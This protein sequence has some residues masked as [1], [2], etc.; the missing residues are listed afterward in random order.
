[1]H[2]TLGTQTIV[3]L[4]LFWIELRNRKIISVSKFDTHNMSRTYNLKVKFSLMKRGEV[5]RVCS[6]MAPQ[7]GV[8]GDFLLLE[9][10]VL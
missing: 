4:L 2:H 3:R 8:R 10:E 9:L 7:A 1:M 5:V 6:S